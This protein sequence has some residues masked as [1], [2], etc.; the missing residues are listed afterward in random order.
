[1]TNNPIT[2]RY[3]FVLYFD[4]KDGNPNGDPDMDN[5]PRFDPE[6]NHGLV[7]DVCIKRKIR[8]F[9]AL[10]HEHKAPYD[11]FV[12]DATVLNKTL[13]DTVKT[14][15]NEKERQKLMCDR[16]FDVRAFGAVL[17]TG[18]FKAGQLRGPVQLTFAR[19]LEPITS[20][21]HSIT[22]CAVTNEKDKEKERTIGRKHSVSYALYK[23]HGYVSA[24]FANQPDPNDPDIKLTG[25]SD[26][27][28]NLLWEALEKMFWDDRSAARGDMR[29]VGLYVFEHDS[30]LGNAAADELFNKVQVQAIND[31]PRSLD[32][33]SFKIDETMP[34][35]VKLHKKVHK[36]KTAL[37]AAA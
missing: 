12:K 18:D 32:D 14:T 15:K 13:E 36:F 34:Q 2:K 10:K 25:F 19:S 31:T 33:Y 22:R 29:T 27:D 5:L 26:D 9:V 4:V 8:N 3:D 21:T 20:L 37:K 28:L 24:S 16:F 35:G 17:S 7:T 11:I 30:K 23:A 1:M 6:D